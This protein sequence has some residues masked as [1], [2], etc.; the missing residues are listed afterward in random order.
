MKM[1]SMLRQFSQ[2]FRPTKAFIPTLVAVVG[3]MSPPTLY[4]DS[5]TIE[6]G[7]YQIDMTVKSS[8]PMPQQEFN[9]TQCV[10]QEEV[11]NG[12]EGLLPD[13][14]EDSPCDVIDYSISGGKIAVNMNCSE[15]G[16]D[17]EMSAVGSYTSTSYTIDTTTNV[18]AVGMSV[19]IVSSIEAK[20]IGDCEG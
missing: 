19:E 6:A 16:A 7:M 20:R 3:L 1:T 15:S 4:A 2:L 18:N 10:T 14:N 8:M 12:P 5:D 13:R 11:E 9:S 17:M